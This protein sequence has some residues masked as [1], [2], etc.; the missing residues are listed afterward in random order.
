MQE[1]TKGSLP[2]APAS[3]RQ[4]QPTRGVI[5]SLTKAL[6]RSVKAAPT[7]MPTAM[8]TTYRWSRN[9]VQGLRSWFERGPRMTVG[10]GHATARWR[11]CMHTADTAPKREPHSHPFPCLPPGL[12]FPR[13]RKSRKPAGSRGA[14]A[15]RCD[16]GW[17]SS[18]RQERRGISRQASGG[19]HDPVSASDRPLRSIIDCL[20]GKRIGLLAHKQPAVVGLPSVTHWLQQRYHQAPP[21]T[22]RHRCSSHI[23]PPTSPCPWM[24]P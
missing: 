2:L 4:A 19:M 9:V 14:A 10:V 13:M 24:S 16:C 5:Q 17:G 7:T 21:A 15:G 8:S 1:I 18:Y 11:R 23:Q 12:T 20:G 3:W 22:H 6:T